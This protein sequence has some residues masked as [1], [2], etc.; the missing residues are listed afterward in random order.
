MHA[1]PS[2]SAH[3]QRRTARERRAPWCQPQRRSHSASLLGLGLLGE[4]VGEALRVRVVAPLPTA[5]QA[6]A[7]RERAAR[8]AQ[9]EEMAREQYEQTQ[10]QRCEHTRVHSHTCAHSNTCAHALTLI[11]SPS[12]LLT[13]SLSLADMQTY[14]HARTEV[15]FARSE[16]ARMHVPFKT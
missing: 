8:D 15:N 4:R 1:R 3:R 6:Q 10:A 13:L 2:H 9:R 14:T 12:H 16:H 7:R 11:C 5:A